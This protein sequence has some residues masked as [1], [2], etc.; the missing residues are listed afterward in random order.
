MLVAVVV[1]AIVVGVIGQMCSSAPN[2]PSSI[3]AYD[4]T[5]PAGPP[6]W[7]ITDSTAS[8][9]RPSAHWARWAGFSRI[10]FGE[11]SK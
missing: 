9:G 4:D 6:S 1:L 11:L 3:A 7:I 5:A 8:M 2:Q 10:P